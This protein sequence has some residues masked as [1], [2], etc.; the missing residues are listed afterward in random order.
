MFE[1]YLLSIK[2]EFY[3]IYGKN[4]SMQP[5]MIFLFYLKSETLQ[6]EESA[7]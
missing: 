3:R 1:I 7:A 6:H 2:K 5:H 4:N